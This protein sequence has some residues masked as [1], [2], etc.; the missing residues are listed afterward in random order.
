[1]FEIDGEKTIKSMKKE[2][3]RFYI[4]VVF[5]TFIKFA[6]TF[7]IELEDVSCTTGPTLF[8]KVSTQ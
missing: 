6:P 1:M 3:T 8:D 4:A 2:S 5:L 7:N